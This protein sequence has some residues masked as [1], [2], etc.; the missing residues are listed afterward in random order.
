MSK[1]GIIILV[2]SIVGGLVV[3]GVTIFAAFSLMKPAGWTFRDF[4]NLEDNYRTRETTL[5]E[6]FGEPEKT[7]T[8]KTDSGKFT[9]DVWG[10]TQL[11]KGEKVLAIFLDGKI[12]NSAAGNSEEITDEIESHKDIRKSIDKEDKY[13]DDYDSSDD[14]NDS[15]LSSK[16][17]LDILKQLD[18]VDED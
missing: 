13:D 2:S 3:L 14:D 17:Y 5:I 7:E 11:G 9:Y 18:D 16:D 15:E 12:Y 4:K 6:K 1:K 8:L 10:N